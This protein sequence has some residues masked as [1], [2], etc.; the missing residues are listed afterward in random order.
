MLAIEQRTAA[1]ARLSDARVPADAMVINIRAQISAERNAFVRAIGMVDP[2]DRVTGR[3]P[4]DGPT[5]EKDPWWS[6]TA[7]SQQREIADSCPKE[8]GAAG[9]PRHTANRWRSRITA[10]CLEKP[11]KLE[12][13]S[14]RLVANAMTGGQ[15]VFGAGTLRTGNQTA[16]A[17]VGAAKVDVSKKSH[18]RSLLRVIR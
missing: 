15:K 10:R 13:R 3:R 8:I 4:P 7:Q 6:G 11:I 9:C 14:Q 12:G 18:S 2:L 16:V 5:E 17:G 1:A